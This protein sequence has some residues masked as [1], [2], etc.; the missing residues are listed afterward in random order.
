MGTMPPSSE[1]C[2]T[3]FRTSPLAHNELGVELSRGYRRSV[4]AVEQVIR[5]HV[6][7]ASVA[8]VVAGGRTELRIP[9]PE[10]VEC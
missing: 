4:G 3:I 1:K 10:A 7:S 9:K 6:T 5:S 8:A 2:N